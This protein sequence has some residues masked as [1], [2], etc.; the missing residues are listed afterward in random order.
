MPPNALNQESDS[1]PTPFRHNH[2]ADLEAAADGHEQDRDLHVDADVDTDS[3]A[4][5]GGIDSGNNSNN[6]AW[7]W[8][9]MNIVNRKASALSGKHAFAPLSTKEDR[10]GADLGHDHDT[11]EYDSEEVESTSSFCSR[12]SSASSEHGADHHNHHHNHHHRSQSRWCGKRCQTGVNAHNMHNS[13]SSSSSSN[14]QNFRRGDG[15]SEQQG[16]RGGCRRLKRCCRLF[17]RVLK[18]TCLVAFILAFWVL[19]C[20]VRKA[21]LPFSR[22]NFILWGTYEISDVVRFI[23]SHDDSADTLYWNHVHTPQGKMDCTFDFSSILHQGGQGILYSGKCTNAP[24]VKKHGHHRHH[25]HDHHAAA[26]RTDQVVFKYLKGWRPLLWEGVATKVIGGMEESDYRYY[27]SGWNFMVASELQHYHSL[28]K[29]M[30]EVHDL[31]HFILQELQQ[32]SKQV[33]HLNTRFF[34]LDMW[35]YNILYR[36]SKYAKLEHAKS[37]S[38]QDSQSLSSSSHESSEDAKNTGKHVRSRSSSSSS[39]S[40]SASADTIPGVI[41]STLFSSHSSSSDSSSSSSSSFDDHLLGH[42]HHHGRHFVRHLMRARHLLVGSSSSGDSGSDDSSEEIETG[43]LETEEVAS[44]DD[45]SLEEAESVDVVVVPS[46]EENGSSAGENEIN[47][48]GEEQ[49]DWQFQLIDFTMA[50]PRSIRFQA[51]KHHID[52]ARRRAP[53][54]VCLQA[55]HHQSHEDRRYCSSDDIYPF[56]DKICDG[57]ID[58]YPLAINALRI[59]NLNIIPNAVD[60][61]E[62]KWHSTLEETKSKH[63]EYLDILD[64][65]EPSIPEE[66]TTMIRSMID[67]RYLDTDLVCADGV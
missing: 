4:D 26:V 31:P 27:G 33:R 40:S 59:L 13:S 21:D 10:F 35:W 28:W 67:L 61:E 16:R 48:D 6:R 2:A 60:P 57:I 58:Q 52:V 43:E 34:H 66:L 18:I 55:K 51:I 24:Y 3:H 12:G 36:P 39:S 44:V 29:E 30:P 11:D 64:Q 56:A 50:M 42:L 23:H 38:N 1:P 20:I 9:K 47:D 63:Q 37:D 5:H 15:Q 49:E 41:L 17:A 8:K 32:V 19:L 45:A 7:W 65:L 22:S 54:A 25:H 46:A 62:S 53:Y 14:R